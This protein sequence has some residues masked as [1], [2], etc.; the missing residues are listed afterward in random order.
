[1]SDEKKQI[2]RNIVSM[3]QL[4]KGGHVPWT[5][6]NTIYKMIN[7]HKFPAMLIDGN[8]YFNLEQVRLW[9]KRHEHKAS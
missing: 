8:Y 3:G 7:D 1:M 5:A 4:I 2:E 9:F 6:R